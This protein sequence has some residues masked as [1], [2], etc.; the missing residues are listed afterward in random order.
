MAKHPPLRPKSTDGIVAKLTLL[1]L[2]DEV[3]ELCRHHK[4]VAEAVLGR[5]KY[6]NEALARH[7]L[8]WH[9]RTVHKMSFPEIGRLLELDHTSVMYAVSRWERDGTKVRVA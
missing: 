6:K 8:C 3:I 7:H 5:S 9:L 2:Y 1:G 4:V